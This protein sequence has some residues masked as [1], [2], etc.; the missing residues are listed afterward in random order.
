MKLISNKGEILSKGEYEVFDIMDNT[1]LDD[2]FIHILSIPDIQLLNVDEIKQILIFE[3][4]YRPI[5]L[6]GRR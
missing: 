3:S 4:I 1:I 6:N 5:S 2:S